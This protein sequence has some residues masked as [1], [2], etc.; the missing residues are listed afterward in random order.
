MHD[1]SRGPSINSVPPDG[2]SGPAGS[3]RL[4]QPP[5]AGPEAAQSG[6]GQVAATA[7][8]SVAD[9]DMLYKETDRLYVELSRG[10]GL[11][12]C[13]YWVMYAIEV[14]GGTVTQRQ[15]IDR[16]YYPK[17][18][19]SSAVRSL[20]GKGLLVL[21]ADDADRR[22]KLVTLTEAGR[23]FARRH[24]DPAMQAEARAFARLGPEKAARLVSL[25]N[26]YARA[27]HAEVEA[28]GCAS[29]R[30]GAVSQGEAGA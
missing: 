29:P 18:T 12:A 3:D 24:L 25:A 16:I 8:P 4:G 1:S 26:E 10:S 14:G 9:L 27:V 11:S 6:R 28:M 19:V 17:Q 13:A 2:W 5:A 23:V 15:I 30:D 20:E 7:A 22:S 21:A